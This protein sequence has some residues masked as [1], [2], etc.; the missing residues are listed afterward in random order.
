[1]N[2]HDIT[3]DDMLN[4]EGLRVVL[5]VAGCAHNCVGCQNPQTHNPDGGVL[6]DD[7]AYREV[8]AELQKDYTSGITFSGGDPLYPNNRETV[9][10]MI[11]DIRSNYPCK[12]I[13]LYS[14][15]TWEQV[16]ADEN[17][18]SIVNLTDVYCDGRF[19]LSERNVS[20]PWVGS[21]NQRVIRVQE[22]LQKGEII[23]WEVR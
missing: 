19:V 17:L 11:E 4:G 3:K 20:K 10:K 9:K 13:W 16:Q 7:S 22:S 18:S 15:Y 14:G 1:M 6:F 5:W 8:M 23:L 12:T 21:N 2:Y